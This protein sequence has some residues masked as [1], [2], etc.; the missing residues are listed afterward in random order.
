MTLQAKM[1]T[2]FLVLGAVALLTGSVLV[3]GY[4]IAVLAL[5]AIVFVAVPPLVREIGMLR[6]S[7]LGRMS[8]RGTGRSARTNSP[9][10]EDA[11]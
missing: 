3:L 2:G 8:R 11:A 6:T 9:A 7:W 10:Q 4:A 1:I 5:G